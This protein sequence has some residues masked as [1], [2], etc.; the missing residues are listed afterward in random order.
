MSVKMEIIERLIRAKPLPK[1][2]YAALVEL[3]DNIIEPDELPDNIADWPK[4]WREEFEERAAIIQYD[5]LLNR[6]EAEQWAETIVRAAYRLST[7]S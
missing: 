1:I 6:E 3:P 4:D 7:D 2:C 5:G